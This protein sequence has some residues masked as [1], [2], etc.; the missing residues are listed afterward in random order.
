MEDKQVIIATTESQLENVLS[1]LIK[2]ITV[3]KEPE[4][5]DERLTREQAAKLADMSL[6]T[7]NK[8]VKKGIFKIHGTQRKQFLLKSEIIE[9]LKNYEQ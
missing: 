6:P 4:F 2:K 1:R 3:N 5:S 8:R 7:L 9:A